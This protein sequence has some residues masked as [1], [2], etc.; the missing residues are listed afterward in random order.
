MFVT[1]ELHFKHKWRSYQARVLDELEQYIDDEK[2]H[3]VAAPGSGK[4]IL[5]L[6]I[7]IRLKQPIL[8]FAPTIAIRDQWIQR[9]VEFFLP[10]GIGTPGWVSKDIRHPRFFTAVTYQRCTLLSARRE[11][12]V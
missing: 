6:E 1:P 7:A 12:E 11:R 10:D 8:V 3:I 2:I 9:L 4:T 5:G